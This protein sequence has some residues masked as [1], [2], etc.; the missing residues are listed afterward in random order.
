M[1]M[2]R[3]S[4]T[5]SMSHLSQRTSEPEYYIVDCQISKPGFGFGRTLPQE[6]KKKLNS[7]GARCR[8]NTAISLRQKS[9]GV[10]TKSY[11][12]LLDRSTF[13]ISRCLNKR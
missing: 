9:A 11:K 8:F 12:A 5:W 7:L 10:I 6:D 4:D 2:L 3:T 13:L 1:I